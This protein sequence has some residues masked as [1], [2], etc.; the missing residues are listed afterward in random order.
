MT[1]RQKSHC[2]PVLLCLWGALALLFY[3][4]PTQTSPQEFDSPIAASSETESL[5]KPAPPSPSPM[6]SVTL[7]PPPPSAPQRSDRSE[8]LQNVEAVAREPDEAS[9]P[10]P[11]TQPPTPPEPRI[12]TTLKPAVPEAAEPDAE[13]DPRDTAPA[14]A[15]TL[16]QEEHVPVETA[17]PENRSVQSPRPREVKVGQIEAQ[18]GRTLLR[19][20]EHGEG[21]LVELAWPDAPA[22]RQ[23]L[24]SHLRACF[25]MIAAVMDQTGRLYRY[26][27]GVF[28]AWSPNMDLFSGFL[29]SPE[30]RLT[31]DEH[32]MLQGA[33]KVLPSASPVRLFARRV[34]ALLLG[35]VASLI[36]PGYG[37]MKNIQGRYERRGQGLVIRDLYGDGKAIAGTIDLTPAAGRCRYAKS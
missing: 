31:G 2:N 5:A 37:R 6:R 4:E 9:P 11:A 14:P 10:S 3:W 21:P 34:D 28:Q 32:A 22:E 25:G 27:G 23:A 18:E 7:P 35:G 15:E 12:V 13:R 26:R 29:R 16:L 36:G 33:R 30:G 24:Y 19:L 1:A 8:E 17:L 20:L